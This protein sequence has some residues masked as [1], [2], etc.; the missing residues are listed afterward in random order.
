MFA[1]YLANVDLNNDGVKDWLVRQTHFTPHQDLLMRYF[2]RIK[3]RGKS[4]RR[5]YIQGPIFWWLDRQ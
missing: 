1:R 2:G 3:I 5:A 4:V